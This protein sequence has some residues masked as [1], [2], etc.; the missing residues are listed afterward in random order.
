MHESPGCVLRCETKYEPLSDI[1]CLV[2]CH[3]S[4]EK[5]MKLEPTLENGILT[6]YSE[7]SKAYRVY[8]PTLKRVVVC[9]DV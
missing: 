1:D 5:R 7:T 4:L 8:I 2:Y 3:V 6:G 9:K